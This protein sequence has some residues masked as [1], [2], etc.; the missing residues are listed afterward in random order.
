MKMS[1]QGLIRFIRQLLR[2]RKKDDW[3][4]N[5]FIIY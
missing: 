2:I 1:M 3:D 5:P 4:N